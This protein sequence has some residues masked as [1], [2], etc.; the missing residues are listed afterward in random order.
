MIKRSGQH[1]CIYNS[2]KKQG[3]KHPDFDQEVLVRVGAS[4]SE[5]SANTP[6][7]KSKGDQSHWESKKLK[8]LI[9]PLPFRSSTKTPP[10]PAVG[11]DSG[12]VFLGGKQ[13]ANTGLPGPHPFSLL[14]LLLPVSNLFMFPC[15]LPVSQLPLCPII[16][17][18][19]QPHLFGHRCITST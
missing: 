3:S 2:K 13:R 4:N 12:K 8:E 5:K 14:R 1:L 11:E 15:L 19:Q 17:H 7:T 6:N 10:A 9:Q 16:L 18:L